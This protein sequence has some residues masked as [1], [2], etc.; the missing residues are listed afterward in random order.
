MPHNAQVTTEFLYA[1]LLRNQTIFKDSQLNG[2]ED[3]PAEK[4][5]KVLIGDEYHIGIAQRI[6]NAKKQAK[7]SKSTANVPIHE[8][9]VSSP[10]LEPITYAKMRQ[11][12]QYD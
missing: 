10:F 4:Q 3:A 6:W 5:L 11:E 1:C 9:R 2:I 7:D 8:L 12:V